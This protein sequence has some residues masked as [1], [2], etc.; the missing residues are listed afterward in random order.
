MKRLLPLG[1][2]A[3]MTALALH[4]GSP[5]QTAPAQD[6]AL[7]LWNSLSDAQK[8]QALRPFQDQERYA[9]VF[10]PVPRP[11]L[12][13]SKLDKKQQALLTQAIGAIATDYGV[14]RIAK[15]ESQDTPRGRYLTFYGTPEKGKPF[16][17][18]L[19]LHHL[20]VVYVEFG[21]DS[22]D[23]FGPILLGGN[24]VGDMWDEEDQLFLAL[25]A[26]LS[27]DELK[28]I[29][30]KGIQVGELSARPRELAKKLLA[31]R[32]KVFNP[33]YRKN[34][35]AQLR[36]D[37]GV[38]KLYLTIDARDASKSHHQGGR[39]YWRFRG[40][41]VFCDW[42]IQGNEHLHLTLRASPRRKG[43]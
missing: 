6:A 2:L 41:H 3:L 20:T 17:W 7:Q 30:G 14:R 38:E 18:R 24:P 16:A 28:K 11:G 32:L 1:C 33:E 43:A 40:E 25:Y 22:P 39:Y 19:A 35:D 15:I 8:K 26:A 23:E 36:R 9:E 13:C 21:S 27:K 29:P 34:F 42:Q 4:S 37:G 31:Q 12:P 5:A 10:P